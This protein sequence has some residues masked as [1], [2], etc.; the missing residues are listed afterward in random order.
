M[1]KESL[2]ILL[3]S[4]LC[5]KKLIFLFFFFLIAAEQPQTWESLPFGIVH[6][7][8]Q[9]SRQRKTCH[10]SQMQ[11]N[12]LGS[13]LDGFYLESVDRK[14]KNYCNR[15]L[16]LQVGHLPHFHIFSQGDWS[17]S[18]NSPVAKVWFQLFH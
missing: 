14:Q 15:V 8:K 9:V 1:E 16:L 6:S 10:S 3:F 12:S 11:I 7:N 2:N 5:C 4:F 17:V 13:N 18:V